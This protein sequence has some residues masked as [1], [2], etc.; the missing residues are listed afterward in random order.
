MNYSEAI[1]YLKAS[2]DE[3]SLDKVKMWAREYGDTEI[4]LPSGEIVVVP[5]P[6]EEDR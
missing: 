6:F 2:L 3:E 5:G 1:G 4:R